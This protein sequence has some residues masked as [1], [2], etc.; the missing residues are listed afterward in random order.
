MLAKREAELTL[1]RV[2][3]INKELRRTFPHR[4]INAIKGH[5]QSREHRLMIENFLEELR[6]A[7]GSSDESSEENF[8]PPTSPTPVGAASNQSPDKILD[9]LESL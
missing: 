4:A 9:Y 1:Q 3:F 2:R 7:G 8:S 6:S 5:R